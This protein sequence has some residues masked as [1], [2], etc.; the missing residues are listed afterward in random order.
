MGAFEA[1]RRKGLVGQRVEQISGSWKLMEEVTWS[2]L[3]RRVWEAE[4][5]FLVHCG[6]LRFEHGAG[7][8]VG[9]Q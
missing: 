4:T 3:P 9:G 7:H 8:V 6:F 5:P 2:D 1:I